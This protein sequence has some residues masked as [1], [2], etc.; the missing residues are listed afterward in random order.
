VTLRAP[1]ELDFIGVFHTLV[2]RASVFAPLPTEPELPP[3]G[4]VWR[5]VGVVWVWR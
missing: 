2:L 5:V 4:V 1:Y 3:V